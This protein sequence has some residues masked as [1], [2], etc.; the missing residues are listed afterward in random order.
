MFPF[1][2]R[3]NRPAFSQETGSSIRYHYTN[4]H[5]TPQQSFSPHRQP[6]TE[7]PSVQFVDNSVILPSFITERLAAVRRHDSNV[8][9]TPSPYLEDHSSSSSGSPLNSSQPNY[10]FPQ[11]EYSRLISNY[12]TGDCYRNRQGIAGGGFVI[13][14]YRNN[15]P[16]E[17]DTK[18]DEPVNIIN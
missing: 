13:V 5:T 7:V 15:I 8:R 1:P 12:R 10:Y 18:I 9:D 16:L 3:Y 11:G 14:Q 4:V 17:I 2:G 6:T